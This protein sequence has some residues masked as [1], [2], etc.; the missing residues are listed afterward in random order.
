[1]DKNIVKTTAKTVMGD[2]FASKEARVMPI[3]KGAV[4]HFTDKICKVIDNVPYY[5]EEG[6]K[7]RKGTTD[8]VVDNLPNGTVIYP[9]FATDEGNLV[10]FTQITRRQNGLN[11][12]GKTNEERINAFLDLFSDEGKLTLKVTDA[13]QR[14]SVY[15]GTETTQNYYNFAVA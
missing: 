3:L 15:E 1:M 5:P 12:E 8:E 7:W 14:N 9:A 10:S 11:L 4:L 13:R 6:G 2:D